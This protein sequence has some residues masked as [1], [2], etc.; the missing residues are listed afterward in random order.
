M[1][2]Y[3]LLLPVLCGLVSVPLAAQE[4]KP[5]KLV[6]TDAQWKARLTPEQ[7]K[8][9]RQEATEAAC[10]GVYWNN[11]KTGTYYCAGCGLALFRA[12]SKFES[13]TGWP[14]FFQPVNK[15]VIDS[16]V[17]KTFGMERTAVSC[18]RCG[19]HLGHVFEDGPK[20]TGLR[21]CINS[22]ALNFKEDAP[23]KSK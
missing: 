15:Y 13:G 7:Y 6:L 22:V 20:P 3:L 17:D 21:F 11:H 1:K 19:G 4:G 18:A 5:E 14:S 9:L 2:K 10:S 8:V 12:E 16:T 23:A